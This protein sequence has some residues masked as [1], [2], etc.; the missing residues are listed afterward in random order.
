MLSF[1]NIWIAIPDSCISDEQTKRDKTVK[2]SQFARACSIFRVK[3]IY[4]YHDKTQSTNREDSILLRTVLQYLDTPQY[5][6][7]RIFPHI[8]QLEYAGVLPPIKSPHHKKYEDIKH[9]RVGD[10]R[11]GVT[12]N[13]RGNLHVDLGLGT[14]IPYP[15]SSVV[16]GQKVN[17]KINSRFPNLTITEAT[18][19]DIKNYYWGYDV[20]QVPNLYGLITQNEGTKVMIT[21]KKGSYFKSKEKSLI[22]SLQTLD[23]LLV[24]FGSPKSEVDEI[25]YS[26]GRVL[27][28]YE[29]IVNMFPFQGTEN[30]RVEEAILGTLALLNHALS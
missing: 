3:R 23:N 11:V 12:V 19:D 30:V 9:V 24:V 28:R 2:I 17:V 8:P 14:L 22:S 25:L 27:T 1:V 15:F 4:I 13:V 29:F 10:I 16:E 7:R 18:A 5:L 26:E 20:K 21:S 6:R